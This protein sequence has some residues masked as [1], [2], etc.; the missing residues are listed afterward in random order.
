MISNC[1]TPMEKASE[2][3]NYHLKPIMQRGKSY[4]KDSGDFINK[5]QSSQNIPEGAIL[6]PA[7]VAGLYPS[8]L[9]EA[10][11]KALR[12]ALDNRENKQIP[13]EKLLEMAEF[14]LKNN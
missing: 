4:I 9:H 1:G 3:L 8:I 14:V 2:F 7:D 12:E 10:G 6:V 5:I 11:L 13:T